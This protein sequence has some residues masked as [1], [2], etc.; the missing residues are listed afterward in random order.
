[1]QITFVTGSQEATTN[2]M[3]VLVNKVSIWTTRKNACGY[4]IMALVFMQA[5]GLEPGSSFSILPMNRHFSS[6]AQD[7]WL[8]N[9][10]ELL[11]DQE[12]QAYDTIVAGA[13]FNFDYIMLLIVASMVHCS[14]TPPTLS[15]STLR[16]CKIP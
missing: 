14:F 4:F 12:Q 15:P 3:G 11:A 6:E 16:F 13:S 7:E 5:I 8:N 9:S 10:D 2:C 1:M